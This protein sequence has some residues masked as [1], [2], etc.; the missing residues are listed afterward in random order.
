MKMLAKPYSAIV[1]LPFPLGDPMT[2]D[3][4][5]NYGRRIMDVM[6]AA[7]RRGERMGAISVQQDIKKALGL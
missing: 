3:E 6:Y 7:N 4:M 2:D 1:R 5:T